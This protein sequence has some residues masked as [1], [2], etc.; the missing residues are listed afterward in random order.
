LFF[1]SVSY[2]ARVRTWVSRKVGDKIEV[3]RIEELWN[4]KSC[5]NSNI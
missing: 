1:Q 5:V 2:E 4:R 3:L